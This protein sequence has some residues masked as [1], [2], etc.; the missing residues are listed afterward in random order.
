M[1]DVLA[2]AGAVGRVVV[3]DAVVHAERVVGVVAHHRRALARVLVADERRLAD[4][5]VRCNRANHTLQTSS[6]GLMKVLLVLTVSLRHTFAVDA[7]KATVSEHAVVDFLALVAGVRVRTRARTTGVTVHEKLEIQSC[8]CTCTL[9][10]SNS[11]VC[12]KL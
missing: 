7:V 11:R 5:E 4:A 12:G 8:T 3:A 2:V 10:T 1:V 6:G 9:I